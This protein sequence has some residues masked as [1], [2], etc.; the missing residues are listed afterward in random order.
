MSEQQYTYDG[1]PGCVMRHRSRA[2]GTTIGIYKADQAGRDG[3]AGE[4]I[5]IC[6]E[7]GERYAFP[8]LRH[9]RAHY[10]GAPWCSSCYPEG[11]PGVP[12]PPPLKFRG[13]QRL[14]SA[15]ISGTG[16]I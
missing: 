13:A 11:V 1:R 2:T 16:D 12:P 5:A 3:S 14:P 7:H 8:N 4:W 15:S 9:A 6:E 10:A